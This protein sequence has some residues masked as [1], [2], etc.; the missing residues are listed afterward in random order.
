MDPDF[1]VSESIRFSSFG[2]SN[3]LNS[4]KIKIYFK[5]DEEWFLYE[6]YMLPTKLHLELLSFLINNIEMHPKDEDFQM[7]YYFIKSAKKYCEIILDIN[8]CGHYS[9]KCLEIIA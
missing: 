2:M 6:E 9:V 1:N 4:S 7:K 5:S 3:K 8:D